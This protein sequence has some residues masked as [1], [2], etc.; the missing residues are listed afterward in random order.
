MF[1]SVVLRVLGQKKGAWAL[2][3]TPTTLASLGS[4][5]DNSS[6]HQGLTTAFIC[7]RNLATIIS[8]AMNCLHIAVRAKFLYLPP[9]SMQVCLLLG[10]KRCFSS[11][12]CHR[13]D[14]CMAGDVC[15][16]QQIPRCF[17]ATGV[18]L[19]I[20]SCPGPAST[21][22]HPCSRTAGTF[23]VWFHLSVYFHSDFL[24][25]PRSSFLP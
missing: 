3:Q 10:C 7:L 9:S 24:L 5:L 8:F 16:T 23:N 11:E 13:T 20:S 21:P 22:S 12:I 1:P 18:R 19:P 15:T 2:P 25:F 4:F 17:S 6:A 14:R